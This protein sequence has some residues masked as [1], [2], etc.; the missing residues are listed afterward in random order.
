MAGR[1]DK[2]AK[3]AAAQEVAGKRTYLKQSD[4]PA[5]SLDDALRVPQTI[6]EHYAG[7]P[8]SPLYLAKA[9]N[10]DYRIFL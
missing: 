2:V 1:K 7:K 3:T 4:V 10:V 8:T 5:A 6:F 9:L